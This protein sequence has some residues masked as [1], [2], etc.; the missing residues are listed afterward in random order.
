MPANPKYPKI[1]FRRA[2]EAEFMSAGTVLASGEPGWATDSKVL[3]VGNGTSTWA[4]L[5]GVGSAGGTTANMVLSTPPVGASG[6]TNI[7]QISQA[8]FNALGS[9]SPN[10]AYL[11]V[12]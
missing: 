4:S 1:Q 5:S 7:V 8:N 12:G 9:Y 3:K 6:I 10:T 2:T 11:I